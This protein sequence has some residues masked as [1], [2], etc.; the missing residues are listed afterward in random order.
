[1][2]MD[3]SQCG[4]YRFEEICCAKLDEDLDGALLRADMRTTYREIM[5]IASNSNP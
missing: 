2:C 3:G 5:G 4:E 1:M